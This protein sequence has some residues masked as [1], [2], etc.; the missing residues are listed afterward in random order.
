MNSRVSIAYMIILNWNDIAPGVYLRFRGQITVEMDEDG[1]PVASN[2]PSIFC[3]R[4]GWRSPDLEVHFMKIHPR[5]SWNDHRERSG[6]HASRFL[7][8]FHVKT[9]TESDIFVVTVS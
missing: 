5:Q 8:I 4:H 7:I 2:A 1:D 6:L 3:I 9:F